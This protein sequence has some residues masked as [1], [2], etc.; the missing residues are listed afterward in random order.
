MNLFDGKLERDD[1]FKPLTE[2]T[3]KN[4]ISIYEIHKLFPI[5]ILIYKIK[6]Q[7]NHLTFKEA[8][9]YLFNDEIKQIFI[10]N[11]LTYEFV[12]WQSGDDDLY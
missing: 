6:Y 3:F 5:E 4:K 9:E 8:S 11:N 12:K 10:D 7:D 2:N 1:E